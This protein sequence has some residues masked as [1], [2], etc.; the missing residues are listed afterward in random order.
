M[1]QIKD[2]KN[3]KDH[4][5]FT[6]E[7]RRKEYISNCFPSP[8]PSS[9]ENHQKWIKS[10]IND[11]KYLYKIIYKDY[12]K[13]GLCWLENIRKDNDA[14]FG[15]YLLRENTYGGEAINVFY[16]MFS[17]GFEKYFLKKIYCETLFSNNL[18]INLQNS[19]GMKKVKN[20]QYSATQILLVTCMSKS[21]F[22]KIKI[23]WL[24]IINWLNSK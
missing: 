13:I 24:E 17:I 15:L 5:L 20:K 21:D 16:K 4:I 6:Y 12:Q 10:K 11:P 23:K 8:P 18:G 9:Y 2:L 1:I 14:E 22:L 19:L 7:S 3:K